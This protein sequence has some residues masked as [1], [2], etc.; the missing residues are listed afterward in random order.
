MRATAT[1]PGSEEA[2]VRA[3][4]SPSAGVP[5]AGSDGAWKGA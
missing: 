2:P 3:N 4:A 5:V 1:I